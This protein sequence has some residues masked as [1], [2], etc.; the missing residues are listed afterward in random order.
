MDCKV[1]DIIEQV[2]ITIDENV[3]SEP[4]VGINDIDT[5]ALDEIIESKVEDGARLVTENA[6]HWLLDEGEPLTGDIT[7]EGQPGKGAGYIDLP[8]DFLR[9][10]TFQMTDWS[11]PATEVITE[12]SPLYALQ[13]SRYGGI[14]GNT[15]KPVVAITHNSDNGMRLEFYSC[16]GGITAVVKRARYIKVPSINTTTNKIHISDKLY[17][18]V[19]YRI[20]SLTAL[21]VGAGDLA[22]AMLKTSM[23]LSGE[24]VT[25]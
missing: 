17:R 10:L 25:A 1:E 20:A 14:R 5:L 24:E 23:D 6:A 21:E 16:T 8:A 18:A 19:V 7:W 2:K 15:Q 4:L 9:L 11:R 22:A 3:S 12:D 13:S